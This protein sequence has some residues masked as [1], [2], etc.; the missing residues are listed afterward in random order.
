VSTGDEWAYVLYGNTRVT[1]MNP[2]RK[3]PPEKLAII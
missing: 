1:V 3:I 2:D